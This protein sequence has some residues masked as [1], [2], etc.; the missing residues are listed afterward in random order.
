MIPYLL[1]ALMLVLLLLSTIIWIRRERQLDGLT[2]EVAKELSKRLSQ[3]QDEIKEVEER[4]KIRE[5]DKSD[6]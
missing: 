5:E 2:R 1:P 3:L 6:H 4:H